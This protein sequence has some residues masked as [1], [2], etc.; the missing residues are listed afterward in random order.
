MKWLAV[1]AL[2]L[3]FGWASPAIADAKEYK[4]LVDAADIDMKKAMDTATARVE[5]TVVKAEL[6][7]EKEKTVYDIEVLSE[8][9][10]FEVKVDAATAEVIA[11]KEDR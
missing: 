10:L 1:V 2:M 8:D 11:V 9:K 7:D 3:S 6:D 4:K 5:G